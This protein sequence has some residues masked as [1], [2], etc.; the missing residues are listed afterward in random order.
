MNNF[1][2]ITPKKYKSLKN[3]P[4]KITFEELQ[5]L[6]NRTP[7]LCYIC[8]QYKEW[9]L[10]DSGLCFSCTTGESDASDD[11]ELIKER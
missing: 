5:I 10:G 11:Y 2:Y 3:N 9:K 1:E 8:H 7:K 6:A 4:D